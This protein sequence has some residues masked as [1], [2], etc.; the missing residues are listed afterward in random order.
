MAKLMEAF[1]PDLTQEAV[2]SF[3]RSDQN[4]QKFNAFFKGD[5]T[6][7]LFVNYQP[8]AGEGEVETNIDFSA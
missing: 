3:I 5:S 4:L 6:G 7:R 8:Q 2:Q 1:A